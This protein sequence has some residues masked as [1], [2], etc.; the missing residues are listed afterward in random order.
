VVG[1]RQDAH[2]GIAQSLTRD[3]PP[4]IQGLIDSGALHTR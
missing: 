3:W 1:G 4:Y 2:D